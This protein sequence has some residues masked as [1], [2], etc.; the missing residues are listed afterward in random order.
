MLTKK[1]NW[2][3]TMNKHV[4]QQTVHVWYSHLYSLTAECHNDEV[5]IWKGKQNNHFSPIQDCSVQKRYYSN[6]DRSIGM[7]IH[8]ACSELYQTSPWVTK[9]AIV[10]QGLPIGE[11]LL[12]FLTTDEFNYQSS[13]IQT[14][15]S[16]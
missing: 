14:N 16:L 7:S 15:G 5:H 4:E 8:R 12:I 3:E 9:F 1:C 6:R 11:K 13:P 2:I 10:A